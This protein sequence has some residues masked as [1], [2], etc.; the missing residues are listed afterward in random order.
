MEIQKIFS[1]YYDDERLYSVLMSEEELALFADLSDYESHRGLGRSAILGLGGGA[2]GGYAG[3]K[4]AERLAREGEDDRQIV[5]KAR[6][7]AG[8][9]G[10][11]AGAAGWGAVGAGT[12]GYLANRVVKGSKEALRNQLKDLSG[13]KKGSAKYKEAEAANKAIKK[14]IRKINGK[15][16]GIAAGVGLG[17][18]ALGAGAG[19]FGG[20]SGANKN[21]RDRIAKKNLDEWS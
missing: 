12:A 5:I 6:N 8:R 16:A 20:R 4:E 9:V 1:D 21:T 2:V 14:S 15:V 11:A 10:A 19:Y 17:A 7:K 18:A 3:K 13:L